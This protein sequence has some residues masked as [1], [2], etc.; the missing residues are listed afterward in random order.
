LH[1]GKEGGF[2]CNAKASRLA[3]YA[4]PKHQ[5]WL[6]MPLFSKTDHIK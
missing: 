2:P 6:A 1:V 4:M 3:C 5:D